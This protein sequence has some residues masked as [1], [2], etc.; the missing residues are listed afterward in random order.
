MQEQ[1]K[2]CT[3]NILFVYYYFSNK[4]RDP[5]ST[6]PSLSEQWVRLPLH[7]YQGILFTQSQPM[8]FNPTPPDSTYTT[9]NRNPLIWRGKTST[10]DNRKGHEKLK[11]TS[12]N[13]GFLSSKPNVTA[14]KFGS[15]HAGLH[16]LASSASHHVMNSTSVL[17][18]L[19]RWISM[20]IWP[21]GYS[22][23]EEVCLSKAVRASNSAYSTSILRISLLRGKDL[24]QSW[25]R[26]GEDWD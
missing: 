13:L 11:H 2:G 19:N 14:N 7:I 21:M 6:I 9:P 4:T 25:S 5:P 22:R 18:R 10:K 15:V 8:P 16:P 26:R 23:S 3:I 12:A 17:P 24:G 1:E 20:S